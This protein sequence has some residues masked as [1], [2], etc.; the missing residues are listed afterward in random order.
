MQNY[1]NSFAD[2]LTL[3]ED[4][5]YDSIGNI[6]SEW[7]LQ[8]GTFEMN[9]DTEG[10]YLECTSSG[11]ISIQNKKAY[12][13]FEF[14]LLKVDASITKIHFISDTKT[15]FPDTDGYCFR[16]M[17]DEGV[18]LTRFNGAGGVSE[19]FT[20]TPILNNDTWYSIKMI[21]TELGVFTTYIKGGSFGTEY[22]LIPGVATGSNPS[23]DNT[24]IISN[25][26]VLDIDTGDRIKNIKFTK[27]IV[28]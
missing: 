14:D 28:V 9:D 3:L 6:P 15:S 17:S 5:K 20:T 19:L 25:F 23:T 26:M 10:K 2:N 8:S 21:R 4:F 1:H 16:F 24:Y 22:V 12:G 18:R 13:T 7:Q 11:E 27:G